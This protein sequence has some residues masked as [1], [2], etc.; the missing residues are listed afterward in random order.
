MKNFVLAGSLVIGILAPIAVLSADMEMTMTPA[1]QYALDKSIMFTPVDGNFHGEG[2]VTRLEFTLATI[3]YL[4]GN[5][6]FEGCYRN[7]SPSQPVSYERLFSDVERTD[8]YGKQ[9]C[10]GMHTGVIQGN[11]DGSFRPFASVTLAEASKILAKAY[12]LAQGAP[13]GEIWYTP[14]VRALSLRGAVESSANPHRSLT[15]E[16]MAKM[17][18]AMRSVPRLTMTPMMTGMDQ[19]EAPT[20]PAYIPTLPAMNVPAPNENDATA[21]ITVTTDQNQEECV[22]Q[23]VGAGS[24]GTALMVLGVEAH[25]RTLPRH[26]RRVLRQQVE[27]AYQNG[28]FEARKTEKTDSAFTRCGAFSAR[29]PGAALM[30]YGVRARPDVLLQRA[31]N[32]TVAEDAYNREHE[33]GVT[34]NPLVP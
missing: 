2:L 26:S 6:D 23:L 34:I 31:S 12:G 30:L 20:T 8:W 5:E 14:A 11:T 17:F 3:N 19:E 4:Y 21:T 33:G 28:S 16:D 7:I 25:P 18:Y 22:G 10:V 15:R 1:A 29:S 27:E 9:L 13:A 32:R 24:P